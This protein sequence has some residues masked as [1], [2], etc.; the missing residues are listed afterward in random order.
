MSRPFRLEDIIKPPPT[1]WYEREYVPVYKKKYYI[2]DLRKNYREWGLDEKRVDEID[3]IMS[4]YK[5]NYV[6]ESKET[7]NIE[8]LDE[9]KITWSYEG[10]KVNI[11][12]DTSLY[13]M[14]NDYISMGVQPPVDLQVRAYKSAGA[15]DEYIENFMKKIER[16]K[17]YATVVDKLIVKVFDKEQKKP[18]KKKKVIEKEPEEEEIIE[19][20]EEDEQE[21]EG[22]E[23]VD[24]DAEND[25]EEIQEEE[26]I[27]EED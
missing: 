23:L 21:E 24:E 14:Y 2:D 5:R 16:K 26:M 20:E 27:L 13:D 19:E 18:A 6:F 15:S 4:E 9:L 1:E 25:E 11:K 12:I 17:K 8:N 10:D 22:E 7:L 3:K